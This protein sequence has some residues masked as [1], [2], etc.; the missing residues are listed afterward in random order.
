MKSTRAQFFKNIYLE[1]INM[2]KSKLEQIRTA[3]S[4]LC[5]FCENDECEK[6]IVTC[7]LNDAE[8]EYENNA[9]EEDTSSC[10]CVPDPFENIRPNIIGYLKRQSEEFFTTRKTTSEEVLFNTD[11]I[12]DLC[13]KYRYAMD[14][15]GYNHDKA[16]ENACDERAGVWLWYCK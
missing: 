4:V 9:E 15:L 14:M 10:Y 5:E 1:V 7:L 3:G 12:D 8:T 13:G 11:L 16:L 2:T 6:C